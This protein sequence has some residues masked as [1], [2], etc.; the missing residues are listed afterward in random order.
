[1]LNQ[2]KESDVD[3]VHPVVRLKE[4]RRVKLTSQQQKTLR[5]P[6][7]HFS[8]SVWPSTMAKD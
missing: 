4:P 1:M 5:D 3:P 8:G 2:T 7:R 6:P